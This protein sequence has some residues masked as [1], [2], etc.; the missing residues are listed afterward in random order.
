M[1]ENHDPDLSRDVEADIA[2]E[3]PGENSQ[4]LKNTEDAGQAAPGRATPGFPGRNQPMARIQIFTG[5][6]PISGAVPVDFNLP[7]PSIWPQE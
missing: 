7:F 4:E 6:P 1:R 2:E 3:Q 5:Q